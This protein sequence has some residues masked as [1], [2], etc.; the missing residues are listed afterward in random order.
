MPGVLAIET[1][2]TR[3]QCPIST[4][5]QL[6]LPRPAYII[7]GSLILIALGQ[8]WVTLHGH[9]TDHFWHGLNHFSELNKL[10]IFLFSSRALFSSVFTVAISAAWAS[11]LLCCLLKLWDR[12]PSVSP[13][14]TTDAVTFT[15]MHCFPLLLNMS[16]NQ[17][18]NWVKLLESGD[19][20]HCP[21]AT[22][23]K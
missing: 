20:R 9:G 23:L 18:Q 5:C 4:T 19:D 2:N 15:Y 11:I 10:F 14:S 12:C 6:G 3:M 8:F 22:T 13:Q 21:L 17:P 16:A 1:G 7:W